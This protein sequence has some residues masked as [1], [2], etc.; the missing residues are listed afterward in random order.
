MIRYV[1]RSDRPWAASV[2]LLARV[3]HPG[4]IEAGDMCAIARGREIAALRRHSRH[5]DPAPARSGFMFCVVRRYAMCCHRSWRLASRTRAVRVLVK[6]DMDVFPPPRS[7]RS[8]RSRIMAV[9]IGPRRVSHRSLHITRQSSSPRHGWKN[10]AR[11]IVVGFLEL[12]VGAHALEADLLSSA[13]A[14]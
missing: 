10:R 2:G 6:P 9:I 4:E 5:P 14:P 13:R 3:F 11:V 8:K 12:A 1:I 7:W